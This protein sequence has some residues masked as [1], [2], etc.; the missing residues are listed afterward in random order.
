[1]NESYWQN[2]SYED[3]TNSSKFRGD[4]KRDLCDILKNNGK[5]IS[6]II[7][8]DPNVSKLVKTMPKQKKHFLLDF[9]TSKPF[10][11][12]SMTTTTTT[13]TMSP[14]NLIS[15]KKLYGEYLFENLTKNKAY[16][17]FDNL[18]FSPLILMA[19]YAQY[20]QNNLLAHFF[21]GLK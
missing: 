9:E 12:M 4:N 19:L 14:T 11:S 20:Y 10:K 7:F 18:G 5:M 16:I 6:D 2:F 3:C 8:K 1:M 13:T 21:R 15:L 17:T